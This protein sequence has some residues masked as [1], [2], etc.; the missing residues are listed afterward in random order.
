MSSDIRER[1]LSIGYHSRGM[2]IAIL[3]QSVIKHIG[4]KQH[5]L[6]EREIKERKKKARTKIT[7]S[8]LGF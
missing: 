3:K 1:E 7:Y 4:W 5:I 8:F 2:F 6:T